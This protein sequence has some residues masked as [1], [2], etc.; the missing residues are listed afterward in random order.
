ML[1]ASANVQQDLPIPVARGAVQ[2]VLDEQPDLVG[3]QEWR[4]DRFALLRTWGSVGLAPA[5][6]AV[7]GRGSSY[8]WVTTPFGCAVGAR[9]DRFTLLAARWVLL[10][11]VV[12]ARSPYR[13]LGLEPPRMLAVGRY[14]DRVTGRSV[15]MICYHLVP[16]VQT[17]KAYRTDQPR[18][19]ALHRS[20]HVRLQRAIDDALDRGDDVYAVGDANFDGFF[21]EGVTSCWVGHEDAPPTFGKKRRHIDDV[22]GPG[23]ADTVHLLPTASDHKAV[24]A[25]RPDF[26]DPGAL[27]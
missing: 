3:L 20:E 4:P 12:A 2:T 17:G 23:M 25:A 14:R 9:A 11:G 13:P 18:L 15:T 5:L 21:L 27:R 1:V 19:V 16:G 10:N 7:P 8:D 26:S 24:L 22:F 6:P